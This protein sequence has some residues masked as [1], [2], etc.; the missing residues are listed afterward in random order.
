MQEGLMKIFDSYEMVAFEP[1]VEELIGFKNERL[2]YLSQRQ[3]KFDASNA[4][5]SPALALF[6]HAFYCGEGKH[7]TTQ[8]KKNCKISVID[9]T[10][11]RKGKAKLE[12]D[13]KRINNHPCFFLVIFKTDK[14][15]SNIL[16]TSKKYRRVRSY[17]LTVMLNNLVLD[18]LKKDDSTNIN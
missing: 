8:G 17:N 11:I 5:T 4:T 2:E 13:L 7:V 16:F 18:G 10:N 9:W 3:C 14:T 1:N 12:D 6:S 15:K